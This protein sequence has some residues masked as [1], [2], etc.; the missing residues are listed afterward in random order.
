MGEQMGLDYLRELLR[1]QLDA[2]H[3]AFLSGLGFS[4]GRG[5]PAIA[6][7]AIASAARITS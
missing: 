1:C 3:R 5:Y 2:L 4:D 6:S 7:K